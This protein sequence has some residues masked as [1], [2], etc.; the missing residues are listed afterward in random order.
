MTGQDHAVRTYDGCNYF[1]NG[2]A[3]ENLGEASSFLMSAIGFTNEEALEY[4]QSLDVQE[5][6]V[7]AKVETKSDVPESKRK[8]V[9]KKIK[10]LLKLADSENANEASA[11]AEMAQRL[12][13]MYEID[14]ATALG[15]GEEEPE[16]EE[17]IERMDLDISGRMPLWKG[18]LGMALAETNGCHLYRSRRF[19]GKTAYVI[20]GQP[21]HLATVAYMYA[22]LVSET[23]RLTKQLGYGEGPSFCHNFREGCSL[24]ISS[25]L[26][27]G[28]KMAKDEAREKAQLTGMTTAIVAVD[29]AI[30]RVDQ[31][32]KDALGWIENQ[33]G[34]LRKGQGSSSRYNAEGRA[35]GRAAGAVVNLGGG[36]RISG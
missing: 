18:Y 9:L 4:I 34:K 32:S 30:E 1:L 8:T 26:K 3:F 21:R 31:R 29:E 12:M 28:H 13:T 25:R 17:K 33:V 10:G 27:K 35:A 36:P 5:R 14:A 11:A 6:K 2:R 24:E 20:A 22:Y 15:M 23:D 19:G 16:A 7:E